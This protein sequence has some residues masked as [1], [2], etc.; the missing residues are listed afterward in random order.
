MMITI[1][2]SGYISKYLPNSSFSKTSCFTEAKVPNLLY[3]LPIA[4]RTDGFMPFPKALMQNETQPVNGS[5]F[6]GNNYY[7]QYTYL[8]VFIYWILLP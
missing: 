5:G 6:Y 3:Y 2:S 8:H 4:K 1:I 7:T